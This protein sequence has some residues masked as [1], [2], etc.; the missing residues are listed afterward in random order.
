M[1][2]QEE[3]LKL[4]EELG[5]EVVEGNVPLMNNEPITDISMADLFNTEYLIEED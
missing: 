2:N 1:F 5:I 3:V 4:C